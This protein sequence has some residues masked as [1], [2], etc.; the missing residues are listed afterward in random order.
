MEYGRESK[1]EY[2]KQVINIAFVPCSFI[3]IFCRGRV[4]SQD[5]VIWGI[6]NFDKNSS[7]SIFAFHIVSVMELP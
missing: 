7:F 4:G 6:F 2:Q 1:N 3:F 5:H